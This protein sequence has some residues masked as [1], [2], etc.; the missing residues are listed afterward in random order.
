M[1]KTIGEAWTKSRDKTGKDAFKF[2]WLNEY[3]Y[4][5]TIHYL[6]VHCCCW[7]KVQLILS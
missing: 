6:V 4:V 5:M 7:A 1:K 2:D 3:G